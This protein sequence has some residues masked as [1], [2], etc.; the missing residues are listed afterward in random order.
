MPKTNEKNLNISL[1]KSSIKTI[2]TNIK[3]L[4]NVKSTNEDCGQLVD[5]LKQ[6]TE[7]LLQKVETSPLERLSKVL[8]KRK[9]KRHRKKFK[10]KEIK[11]EVRSRNITQGLKSNEISNILQSNEYPATL[12]YGEH[13]SSLK[14]HQHIR[15]LKQH[16]AQ[17]FLR[18]FELFKMLH[19][20]RGQNIN[21]TNEFAEQLLDL[22]V[23]WSKILEEN[24]LECTQELRI[25]DQ[26]NDIFFGSAEHSY[27]DGDQKIS[28]FL[29][30][31]RIWDSY[32]TRSKHGSSIPSGW[33]LP[34]ENALSEWQQYRAM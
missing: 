14:K 30:I 2:I 25:E 24:K 1:L 7:E 5:R 34:S 31:R 9:L 27:Y 32:L 15:L 12:S 19:F 21:H 20:S 11:A 6:Q 23:S 29:R 17:R 8:K 13:T 16:D 22:R 18:T 3:L 26:W 28:E 33:V 4:E 10:L